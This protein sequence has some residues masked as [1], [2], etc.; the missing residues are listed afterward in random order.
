ME[1]WKYVE[2]AISL[3]SSATDELFET[4]CALKGIVFIPLFCNI[5][6]IKNVIVDF[7]TSEAVPKIDIL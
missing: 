3:P 1:A 6:A 2:V 7:P 5:F 4:F